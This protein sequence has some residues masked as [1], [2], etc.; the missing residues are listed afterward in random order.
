MELLKNRILKDGKIFPGSIVKV[1]SF[2][3]HQMDPVFMHELGKEF[4]RRFADIKPT[5]IITVEASGIGVALMVGLE[6]EIPVIFAKKQKTANMSTDAYLS[7]V[8][9]YTRGTESVI[10][11]SKEYLNSEDRAIIIDDFLAMGQAVLGLID[12]VKQSGAY[13]GGV[14]IVIEKGFQDG[15]KQLRQQGI[16]LESL[17]IIKSIQDGKIVFD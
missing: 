6:F 12:I 7:N 2:L 9:S 17:A 14:G 10:A 15:G 13:L 1:D 3:N 16:R 5:K 4:K 8:K 11:V